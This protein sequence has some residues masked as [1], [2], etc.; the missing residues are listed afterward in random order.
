MQFLIAKMPQRDLESLSSDFLLENLALASDSF[1]RAPWS[2]AVP[3]DIFL[4]DVLPYASVSEQ[5]DNWRRTLLEIAS[6]IVKECR[7]PSEAAQTLNRT[8]FKQLKV[9]YSTKRRAPDQGPFETMKT[10][11]ATCTGLSILLVDACR[12]VGVPARVVGTPLWSNNTGNHTWVEIWDGDWHFLGAAEPDPK[13]L[14][15]GWFVGNASKAVKGDP[16]HAIYATTFEKSGLTFPLSWAR[17]VDYVSAINVTDRYAAKTKPAESGEVI[18]RVNVLDKPL[19]QRVAANVT[20]TDAA[21]PS[22]KWTGVSKTDPA[23]VNDHIGFTIKKQHTFIVEAEREG[24]RNR[25]YYT[26]GTNAEDVLVVHLTGVPVVAVPAQMSCA[27]LV[28]IAPLKP[29]DAAKLKAAATDFFTAPAERQAKWK[30]AKSLDS[31]LS[32]NEPTVRMAVWESYKGAPIRAEEKRGFDEN[33]ARAGNYTSPYTV[34]TVGTRPEKGWAL[35]I[36]MH[37]GGGVAQEFND[38]QWRKMQNYYRDHPEVGGYKYVA[39]RAP[40]NEWNGFYTSYMYPV[41]ESLVRQFLVFGDVDPNKVFIMGYSHGGYGAFAIGPK[42]ADRFAAIHASAAALADSAKPETLRNTPF[43]FMVGEKD[44]DYGRIKRAREFER[45]IQDLRG[46]RTDIFPVT[47]TVIANHPHSGLPDRE[48][49]AEMYP[50]VRNP[51]PRELTWIM[52]DQVVRGFFWLQT[53][54]PNRGAEIDA[55]CRDNH[56][57]VQTKGAA[58]GAVLL[59]SRLV[60]FKQPVLFDLNGK[61][62]KLHPSPSLRTL[63]ETM[64]RRGDPWLAFTARIELAA[65]RAQLDPATGARAEDGS[66]SVAANHVICA[67]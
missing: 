19:G 50:A 5:R 63:C 8:M 62:T 42:M 65:D 56:L 46:Q 33:K 18:L 36:A 2:K 29:K 15:R 55:D 16:E 48:K 34:K 23:D 17:S 35:F 27:A 11:V 1:Q 10:G 13:G 58:T 14:D 57:R 40:N 3:N 39:L 53:D 12:A 25:R 37:G 4:N 64:Q 22:A 30:F 47:V 31:M 51:V 44:T 52:T 6:P 7:T 24:L 67:K 43:T 9:K 54:N 45:L 59:D 49:I 41:I 61:Q 38:S 26:S 60:D 21:E 28:T 32:K 66:R 20:V